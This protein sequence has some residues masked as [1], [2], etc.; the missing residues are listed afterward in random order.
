MSS[1]AQRLSRHEF[2]RSAHTTPLRQKPQ[3]SP[4]AAGRRAKECYRRRQSRRLRMLLRRCQAGA[5]AFFKRSV[6]GSGE[7]VKEMRRM[8][9]A[10]TGM[11]RPAAGKAAHGTIQCRRPRCSKIMTAACDRKLKNI[12]E[13]RLKI[14]RRNSREQQQTPGVRRAQ[15]ERSRKSP[16]RARR[17]LSPAR[18]MQGERATMS[19]ISAEAC[20][21]PAVCRSSAACFFFPPF[22]QPA[23]HGRQKQK[24]QNAARSCPPASRHKSGEC[25]RGAH[26]AHALP[27][28]YARQRT[29]AA[30]ATETRRENATEVLPTAQQNKEPSPQKLPGKCRC[31]RAVRHRLPPN[32]GE[33]PAEAWQAAIRRIAAAIAPKEASRRATRE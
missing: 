29:R 20:E 1:M 22:L 25:R 33:T 30:A 9:P 11:P 4:V 10:A 8:P 24:R 27:R 23:W 15:Q 31:G 18:R 19:Q 17:R 21:Q 7:Q 13:G 6:A 32:S 14:Q 28:E 3:R 2:R 5:A 16:S 12:T 26:Y